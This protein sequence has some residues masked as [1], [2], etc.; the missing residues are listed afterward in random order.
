MNERGQIT[1]LKTVFHNA[2][3]NI[4]GRVLDVRVPNF[5]DHLCI[6]LDIINFNLGKQFYTDPP[7]RLGYVWEYLMNSLCTS[8]YRWR[9]HWKKTGHRHPHCLEMTEEDARMSEDEPASSHDDE[10]GPSDARMD[11]ILSTTVQTPVVGDNNAEVSNSAVS[12]L[13]SSSAF[14]NKT[15]L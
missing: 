1:R 5:D 2:I 11:E 12:V 3:R 14:K 4:V 9:K 15:T 13:K 10:W 6:A 7:L 8:R